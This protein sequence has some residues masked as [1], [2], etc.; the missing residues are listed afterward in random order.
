MVHVFSTACALST[1]LSRSSSIVL[2]QLSVNIA[3]LF[4]RT[5]NRNVNCPSIIVGHMYH[6][7]SFLMFSYMVGRPVFDKVLGRCT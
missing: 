7:D 3:T 6:R 1:D 2:L 4:L 5:R